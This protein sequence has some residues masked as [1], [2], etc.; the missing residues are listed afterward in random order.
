MEMFVGR[1]VLVTFS[2]LG[3]LTTVFQYKY[4]LDSDTLSNTFL[5]AFLSIYEYYW[6][7]S[8]LLVVMGTK[9]V[10]CYELT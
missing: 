2:S 9:Y 7:N 5:K 10:L 4:D 8:V 1:S 3:A 6:S